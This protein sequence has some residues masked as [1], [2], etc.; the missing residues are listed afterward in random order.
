[1]CNKLL[2]SKCD[3]SVE[4][5]KADHSQACAGLGI[6]NGVLT[7]CVRNKIDTTQIYQPDNPK[8]N[9]DGVRE[10][11]WAYLNYDK[12]REAIYNW[13]SMMETDNWITQFFTNNFLVYIYFVLHS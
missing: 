13:I 4:K 6:F 8:P 5:H 9:V 10:S 3:K 12:Y 1:M 2:C 7:I 11:C